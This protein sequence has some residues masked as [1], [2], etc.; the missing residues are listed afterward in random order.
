M[1]G[2]KGLKNRQPTQKES[3]NAQ[4]EDKV[5]RQEALQIHGDWQGQSKYIRQNRGTSVMADADA[6]KIKSYM[7]YA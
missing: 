4:T 1:D 6:K 3:E 2:S 5:W 7:P